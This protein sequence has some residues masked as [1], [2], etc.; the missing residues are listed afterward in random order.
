MNGLPVNESCYPEVRGQFQ[1]F[2]VVSHVYLRC[3][4]SLG[5]GDWTQ[6][7]QRCNWG[8]NILVGYRHHDLNSH[9]P[10]PKERLKEYQARV[11][12]V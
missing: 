8:Y 6:A 7:P 11:G 9:D 12:A 4:G 3:L 1:C 10:C 2:R 5:L